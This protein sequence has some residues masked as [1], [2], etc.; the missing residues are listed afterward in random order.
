[1]S[2][3]KEDLREKIFQAYQ[4][5]KLSGKSSFTTFLIVRYGEIGEKLYRES[6]NYRIRS[7]MDDDG[8]YQFLKE[9][10][11]LELNF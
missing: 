2:N 4:S 8:F 1:M 10:Y 5:F 6:A 7:Q 3:S 9:K 11:N